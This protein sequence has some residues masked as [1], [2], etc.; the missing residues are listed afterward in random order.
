MGE[1]TRL[2]LARDPFPGLSELMTSPASY[3]TTVRSQ[4]PAGYWRLEET[5]SGT[6]AN[7]I[8]DGLVGHRHPTVKMGG[9]GLGTEDGFHGFGEDNRAAQLPGNPGE[10]P[11]SLGAT[12]VHQGILFRDDFSGTGPLH[13]SLP[14]TTT[15]GASWVASANFHM[16]GSFDGMPGSATLAFTPVD[17]VVYTLDASLRDVTGDDYWIAPGFA[18]GQSK[19]GNR[20]TRFLNGLVVGRAWMALKAI[21]SEEV[22]ESGSNE[23]KAFL[24][25][26]GTLGGTADRVAFST[27]NVGSY[28][29]M[30]LRIVLDTNGGP[31]TWTATWFAKRPADNRYITVRERATLLNESINSIGLAVGGVGISGTVESFSLQADRKPSANPERRSN[32]APASVAR[33]EGSVSLWM[34]SESVESRQEILWTAGERPTDD[35]IHAHLTAD[36]RAGFFMENGRYDVLL[37]SEEAINDGKW[38][39]LAA[40]WSP[41]EVDLY[42]DG[43]RVARDSDY[44]GRQRGILPELR[45]GGG[46][47]Y[48]GAAPFTGWLDEIALWD[49]PLTVAE[50]AHQYQ[51]A[52]GNG[53]PSTKR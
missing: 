26:T 17:G 9:P 36:G 41:S 4:N 28:S 13:G 11:L 19:A 21:A 48:S 46:P 35:S 16:D 30:D 38:H 39:H 37:V 5:E 22:N 10:V 31:G 33:K 12:P 24:G 29:D 42:L 32:E 27:F 15:G 45:F 50:V 8:P 34:R 25:T 53:G 23:N 44:R 1:P 2:P 6:L 47:A 40:S 3:P 51:S 14:D 20:D 49:R 43:K 52:Q 18:D 7:E